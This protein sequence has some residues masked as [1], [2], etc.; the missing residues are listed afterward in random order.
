MDVS[1]SISACPSARSSWA[2]RTPTSWR[3]SHGGRPRHQLRRDHRGRNRAGRM[4]HQGRHALSMER[5]R[6]VSSGT[7]A[8]MTAVRA[9][10]R[11]HGAP[12]DPEI[13]RLLPRPL[14]RHA[15]E[16]GQRRGGRG[17]RLLRRRAGRLHAM[18]RWWRAT[19]IAR[20]WRRCCAN[21]VIDLA[22]IIVEPVAAN[23]GLIL[24][25]PGF[26]AFLRAAGGSLR[27]PANVRR[28]DQRVPLH[29]RRL[30]ACVR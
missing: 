18:T 4:A 6:L 24:P 11:L 5:V 28:S 9:G 14:R 15:G 10:A 1:S 21:T 13:Q 12:Q 2:M 19:T 8:C 25:E 20:T 27:R 22:A 26:L 17:L 3:P 30:P 7:E 23:V 16:G 29:L